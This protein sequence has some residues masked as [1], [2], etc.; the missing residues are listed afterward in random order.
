VSYRALKDGTANTI[1]VVDAADESAVI[2]LNGKKL[3]NHDIGEYGWDQLFTCDI[4]GRIHAGNNQ[5]TI[6]VLDR[7]GAGGLYKSI[8]IL[9]E[10]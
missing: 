8:K 7:A 4:T 2:W 5:L 9:S 1:M 3:C 10:K 6:R